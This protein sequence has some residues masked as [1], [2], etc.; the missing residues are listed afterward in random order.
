[1]FY[2]C[3]KCGHKYGS[4]ECTLEKKKKKKKRK[5]TNMMRRIDSIRTTKSGFSKALCSWVF[6]VWC[7]GGRKEG[8]L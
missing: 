5:R 6:V 3:D 8:R 7:G 2:R 4:V 1:M